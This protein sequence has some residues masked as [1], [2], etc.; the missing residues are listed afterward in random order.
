MLR[1]AG[2][3]PDEETEALVRPVNTKWHPVTVENI[4]E[5]VE[6]TFGDEIVRAMRGRPSYTD[7]KARL[8]E[9]GRLSVGRCIGGWKAAGLSRREASD[10]AADQTVALRVQRSS[11]VLTS[12]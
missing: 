6:V 9:R 1:L 12:R 7:R 11:R 5:V 2:A 3:T 4:R 10:L 8:E